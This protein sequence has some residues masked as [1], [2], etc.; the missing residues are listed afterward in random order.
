[1]VNKLYL[2]DCLAEP[3]EMATPA[4]AQ[5]DDRLDT[6]H[7]RLGHASKQCVKSMAYGK[8]VTGIGL[9]KRVQLLL[10][11]ACIEGRCNGNL[12]QPSEKYDQRGGCRWYI[13][14]YVVQCRQSL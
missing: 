5:Q 2:L 11:E 1:M 10:C 12:S 4:S 6:W 9:P 7:Y 13:V 14:T 8:L 3:S